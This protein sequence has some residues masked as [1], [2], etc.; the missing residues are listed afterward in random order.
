MTRHTVT[1]TIARKG[2]AEPLELSRAYQGESY[3]AFTDADARDRVQQDGTLHLGDAYVTLGDTM[4]PAADVASIT[5][6]VS[7]VTRPD[8]IR[9]AIKSD[10]RSAHLRYQAECLTAEAERLE[11]A[12]A[13]SREADEPGA[14]DLS[15]AR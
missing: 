11:A 9:Q 15:R 6:R 12:A 10:D 13:R 3:D 14:D 8:P 7:G 1:V 4:I 2:D 5:V